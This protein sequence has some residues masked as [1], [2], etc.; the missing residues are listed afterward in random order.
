VRFDASRVNSGWELLM[1][2]STAWSAPIRNN[3]SQCRVSVVT[4]SLSWAM[5]W[6]IGS[7]TV[8]TDKDLT[9]QL[10]TN[11]V[12]ERELVSL[13]SWCADIYISKV[14]INA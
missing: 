11:W 13:N 1:L 2:P 3:V 14:I 7:S 4:H 6:E 5:A 10:T 8:G 9:R 12:D